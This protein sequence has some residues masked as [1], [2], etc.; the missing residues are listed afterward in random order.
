MT[1][2]IDELTIYEQSRW[3]ALLDAIDIIEDECV[4]LKRDF[5]KIKMSPIGIEK[6]INSTFEGYARRIE[7]ETEPGYIESIL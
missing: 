3:Y 4:R 6:Y 1:K 2:N 7:A 5:T